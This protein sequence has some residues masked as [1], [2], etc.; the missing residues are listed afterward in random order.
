MDRQIDERKKI[1]M[2]KT[3]IRTYAHT[4]TYTY[5]VKCREVCVTYK[6]DSGLTPYSHSSALQII[7]RYC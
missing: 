2:E 6:T 4:R 5:I 3:G 7:Q 1:Y